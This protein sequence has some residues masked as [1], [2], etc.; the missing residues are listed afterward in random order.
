MLKKFEGFFSEYEL[1]TLMRYLV[2]NKTVI[3]RK[4]QRLGAKKPSIFEKRPVASVSQPFDLMNNNEVT[5]YW[6]AND[7][8]LLK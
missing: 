2:D 5:F 6:L 3:A 4:V 8:Y 7:Y 1:Y